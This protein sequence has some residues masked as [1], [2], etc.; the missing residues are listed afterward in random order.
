M[1]GGGMTL[2]R[3]DEM[4]SRYIHSMSLSSEAW[5]RFSCVIKL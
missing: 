1:S 3:G 5:P 2:S 4:D